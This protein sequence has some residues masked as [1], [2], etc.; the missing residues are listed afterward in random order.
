MDELL[1]HV[2]VGDGLIVDEVDVVVNGIVEDELVD[3]AEPVEG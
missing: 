1:L 3:G 2:P